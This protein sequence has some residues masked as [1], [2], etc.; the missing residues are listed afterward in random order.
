MI[1]RGQT[2]LTKPKAKYVSLT[3]APD[4]MMILRLEPRIFSVKMNRRTRWV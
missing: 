4:A 3:Q 1:K 2:K